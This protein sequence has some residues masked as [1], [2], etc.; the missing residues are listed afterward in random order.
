MPPPASGPVGE[1][2]P[3][4]PRHWLLKSEPD[5]Y[6]FDDLVRD[7][8]TVWDGVRNAQAANNLKAMQAGDPA[9]FYHSGTGPGV[10]GLA[11]I[12]AA[13]FPDPNDATG[14][15]V[16]VRVRPVRRLRRA[17]SLSVIKAEPLLAQMAVV[18][19]GRLSVSPVTS[20]EWVRILEL[21]G[22]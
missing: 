7:G 13:A 20:E 11:E 17:V 14:R 22:A 21:A 3:S 12:S 5:S 16:A 2:M 19:Q 15:F 9:L 1:I 6:S 18:R 10:V 8:E 4:A